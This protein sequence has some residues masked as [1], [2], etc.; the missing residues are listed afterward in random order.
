MG[1]AAVGAII[2]LFGMQT[3]ILIDAV[4]F[5][6]SALIIFFIRTGEERREKIILN[7][8]EYIDTLKGGMNYIRQKRVILN[9]VFLAMVA[10]AILIPMNSLQA[11]LVRDVLKQEEYMLSVISFSLVLGLGIGSAVYP[12]I[13]KA[14][15][16]P[17]IVL[18]GGISISIYYYIPR[19]NT[20]L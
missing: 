12:Y 10:N 1:L 4:T 2:A 9:F 6:G 18:L 17:A 5:W 15:R 7:L 8:N 14:L 13:A 3:A 19:S 20:I 11:P 16:T